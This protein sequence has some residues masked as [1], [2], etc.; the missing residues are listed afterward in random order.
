MSLSAPARVPT[1]LASSCAV[2]TLESR[3]LLAVVNVSNV[4]QLVNAV[5]NGAAG[6]QINVAAGTYTLTAPLAPKAGMIIDGAGAGQTIITGASTWT[7]STA[8]LPDNDTGVSSVNRGAYLFSFP[9]NTAN[10]KLTDMTLT[11]PR[12]H[13]AVFGNNPDGLELANLRIDDFLWSGVRTFSMDN[14]RIH[15]NH[16]VNAGGRWQSGAPGVSG[17]ITGGGIYATWMKTSEIWNNR[18]DRTNLAPEREYYGIK[19]REARNTRVHHNTINVNFSIEFPHEN[20]SYVEIDHN[21][22]LGTV[23]IPKHGGGSVPTG[24]NPYTFYIHHNYFRPSYSLEWARNGAEVSHNLFDFNTA[25]DKGN[26][27]SNFAG[28]ANPV[29][30]GPTKF[31][32]NLIKNPGRGIYASNGHVYNNFSFYNNH[33]IGNTTATPRTEGMFGLPTA[34]TF[35]TIQIKDNIFQ[36]NGQSRPLFRNTASYASVIS[37]NALT[38][39]SDAGNYSNPNTGATRG[40]TAPLNFTVGVNNQYTVNGWNIAPTQSGIGAFTATQDIGAVAAAGSASHANGTY[41]VAG[42]GADIWGAADEFRYLYAPFT[43]DGEIVARVATLQN[44][45]AWAKSGI[46]FRE[47]LGAGSRHASVFVTPSNGV[48]FQIRGSANGVSAQQRTSGI[49]APR[50]IKLVRAGNA[51]TAYQSANGST[52]TQVWTTQTVSMPAT[53]YVGLAVTSHVDGTLATST[54]DNV[55]IVQAA[56]Q[57]SVVTAQAPVTANSVQAA[58]VSPLIDFPGGRVAVSHDGNQHD[59]DEYAAMPMNLALFWAAGL[60]SKIVHLDHSNH[61]GDNVATRNQ[62]MRDLAAGSSTRFDI[63]ASRIFD[64]QTQLSAA[65]ANFKAEA[66]KST[67]SDPLW[68]IAAGPMEV[69]WRMINAVGQAYRQHIKVISHSTWNENHA[70]TT[71]MT[72]TWDDIKQMGV[73]TYDIA[74]QNSSGPGT[75]DWRSALSNWY[76]LRDS[77]YEPYRWIYQQKFSSTVFDASDAGMGFWLLSGGPNG[78]NQNSGWRE[79]KDVLEAALVNDTTPPAAPTGLTATA[80]STS[81]INL[82]WADSTA[83]DLSHYNVYRST[84]SGSGYTLVA[85]NLT[86]SSYSNAGLAANTTYYY[87]VKAVDTSGNASANSSQASAKTQAATTQS[88]Y[89]GSPVTISASGATRIQ[90]ENYDLGGHGVAYFDTGATNLGNVYRTDG[91]DLQAT[92]DT[93]GGYNVGWTANGEWLEYTVSVPTAGAYDVSFRVAS[94]SANGTLHLESNGVNLTGPVSFTT[95]GAWQTFKTVTVGNVNLAAGQQVLRVAFDAAN[96]NLNW[97]E[98][99]PAAQQVVAS[100]A[101]ALAPAAHSFRATTPISLLLDGGA[102]E[103]FLLR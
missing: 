58:A 64:D 72:H 24:T 53:I 65:I 98:F 30:N 80:V 45:N 92:T 44:T 37:N 54:L 50:W 26:L 48:S 96:F 5:N 13:G 52:W 17:G 42:S 4:S 28:G 89:G 12:L 73:V 77:T 71:Q 32:N 20:D 36:F 2:E 21:Y 93:G 91:V 76:W 41:T 3:T 47:T 100:S 101:P 25:E 6:D 99:A 78:G 63:P 82:D 14:A 87:V 83:P 88:P 34:T 86:N 85:S 31:H 66:E 35:S 56:A 46:M 15:D 39:V 70:D 29:S 55:S 7:P 8:G 74:D 38:N 11:G 103:D 60:S 90:A 61:L 33:V 102:E 79:A 18:F 27:I 84:T 10:V 9:D 81:Q 19:G 16:F 68:L 43:G 94:Q 59:L 95:T 23:S 49:A 62:K 75:D 22:L 51:F 1:P 97:L 57:Q 69:P 40:P 67:A